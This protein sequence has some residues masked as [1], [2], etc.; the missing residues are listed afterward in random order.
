M[1]TA[2]GAPQWHHQ[3]YYAPSLGDYIK[4]SDE[5]NEPNVKYNAD[6]GYLNG[7][8]FTWR[9]N[10]Y[11]KPIASFNWDWKTGETSNVSTVAYASWGRGGGTGPIGKINGAAEYYGQ[12]RNEDGLVRFDDIVAWN[13][14]ASVPDFGEDREVDENGEFINERKKGFTRRASMNS[15]DWYGVISNFHKD[16]NDNFG[17]DLGVD[18]RTYKGMHYRIVNDDLGADG[19][20]NTYKD[21]NNMDMLITEYYEAN[22]S[23]NPFTN[24]IDQQKIEYYN[25]G[26]ANWLGAFGQ[27]EYKNDALSAFMQFGA[28]R[29]GFQRSDYFNILESDE[30]VSDWENLWGGNLKGGVNYNLNE[31]HNVFMN[32]GYYSKQPLFGAVYPNY[33]N[34][35]IND[36]LINEKIIGLEFG[37]GYR[38]AKASFNLNLYRTS[39]ADRYLQI[40]SGDGTARINGVT[41]LH[42]GVETDAYYRPL[43]NLKIT[44]MMSVG[45]WTYSG[46]AS[47]KL[48]DDDNE[49]LGDYELHLDGVKVG[50]AAQITSRLGVDWT[51]F[52]NFSVNADVFYADKLYANISADDF[53]SPDHDGSLELPSYMLTNAGIAYKFHFHKNMGLNLRINVNNLTDLIYISESDTNKFADGEDETWEGIN[54]DNRVW[55]GFGRTWNFSARFTF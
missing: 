52:D 39:W 55:F 24:I 31:H 32:A 25:D 26:G 15:H 30:Q 46:N 35:D 8:E 16:V 17:F 53:D 42:L 21:V 9:R 4:Y 27:L 12:F 20:N 18:L 40:R 3:R 50:D 33:T 11:H 49:F 22:P 28:S 51:M 41:Q 45:N 44:G 23:W 54:T 38:A 2:T 37:Y 5:E 19:Y 29:Q 48:Y 34:N 43:E 7:E 10:F 47:G 1:F 14:G 36:D 13:G 6:W